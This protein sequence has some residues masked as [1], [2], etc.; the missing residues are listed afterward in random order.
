MFFKT[1]TSKY[2]LRNLKIVILL[3]DSTTFLFYQ[4]F[5]KITVQLAKVLEIQT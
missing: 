3:L 4:M 5:D 2:H 1:L